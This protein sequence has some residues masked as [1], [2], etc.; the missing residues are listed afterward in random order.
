MPVVYGGLGSDGPDGAYPFMTAGLVAAAV[1]RWLSAN[2]ANTGVLRQGHRRRGLC[3]LQRSRRQRRRRQ[4]R[5]RWRILWAGAPGPGTTGG[6][7]YATA[8][9]VDHLLGECDR[10]FGTPV[11]CGTPGHLLTGELGGTG[12]K[13]GAGGFAMAVSSDYNTLMSATATSSASAGNGGDELWF[14][15]KIGGAGGAVGGTTAP[16]S[17][18][19]ASTAPGAIVSASLTP[20]GRL[21]VARARTGRTAGRARQLPHQHP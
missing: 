13:G 16:S 15:R 5:H 8:K 18:A 3:Q 14:A 10:H 4:V 20:I 1:R 6:N 11:D 7:A 19:A 21:A 12:N 2:E 17:A 9:T